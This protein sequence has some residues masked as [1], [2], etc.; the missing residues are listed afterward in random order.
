MKKPAEERGREAQNSA[1]KELRVGWEE[2]EEEWCI[3][4]ARG[5]GA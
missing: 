2:E 4:V 3:G 5:G 1:S